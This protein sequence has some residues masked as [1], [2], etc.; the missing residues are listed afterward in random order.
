LRQ[1][2][3]SPDAH[4]FQTDLVSLDGDYRRKAAERALADPKVSENG[5]GTEATT[6]AAAESGFK[7]QDAALENA[8]SDRE[9]PETAKPA[10]TRTPRRT[11]DLESSRAR[12]DLV[13]ALARE[14][15]AIKQDLRGYCSVADLKQ[16]HPGFVLW[17]HIEETELKELAEGNPFKPKGYAENLT[18]RFFG[19]T[20]RETLKKDRRKL[21]KA[22][23]DQSDP[24]SN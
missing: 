23:R 22:Q 8:R 1:F 3:A 10:L 12:V 24:P 13:G 7:D 6:R 16:K 18:L 14:L 4:K 2:I 15:A 17:K 20:S 21:R 9:I 11:P 19:I 5:A